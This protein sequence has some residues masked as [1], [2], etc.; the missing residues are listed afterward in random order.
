MAL[1]ILL[2]EKF[3]EAYEKLSA[4]GIKGA[5]AGFF[6][7]FSPLLGKY[8]STASGLIENLM[9]SSGDDRRKISHANG[10]IQ[11]TL[12]LSDFFEILLYY[13]ELRN[14]RIDARA[15][16]IMVETQFDR[17]NEVNVNRDYSPRQRFIAFHDGFVALHRHLKLME[18]RFESIVQYDEG[19]YASHKDMQPYKHLRDSAKLLLDRLYDHLGRHM[20]GIYTTKEI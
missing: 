18:E 10:Q 15:S 9:E 3:G 1:E 6:L 2:T 8:N 4:E 5:S 19:K 14:I 13:G 17:L 7:G 16:L 11:T 20:E 12:D